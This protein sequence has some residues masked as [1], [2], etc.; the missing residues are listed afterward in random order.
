MC[1]YKCGTFTKA[2]IE[3]IR[4]KKV[5]NWFFSI[6]FVEKIRGFVLFVLAYNLRFDIRWSKK[7]PTVWI[8]IQLSQSEHA[9]LEHISTQLDPKTSAP[10]SSVETQAFQA[11][12]ETLQNRYIAKKINAKELSP[13]SL[14]QIG[15]KR[16]KMSFCCQFSHLLFSLLTNQAS[17]S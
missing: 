6:H 3:Q 9:P 7:H 10:E 1:R 11:R 16:N 2:P 5:N 4:P 15:R 17:H 14:L 8:F 12:F 13:E